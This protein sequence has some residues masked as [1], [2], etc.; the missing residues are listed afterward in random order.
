MR[1]RELLR[2]A[3]AG[4]R[5]NPL[6]SVLTALG[7]IIG[8]ASVMATLALGNGAR[9][10][11]E[12]QFRTLGS[13]QV[14]VTA[15]VKLVDGEVV[16]EGKPLSYTDGLAIADEIDLVKRVD[17]SVS[18]A[19]K[20]RYGRAAREMTVRGTA[21]TGLESVAAAGD[22]ALAD[23][24][25]GGSLNAADLLASGRYFSPAEAAG[26]ARVCVLG[27][28]TARELMAGE[29]PIGKVVR[30]G[31]Q[32]ATVIGVL[33]ELESTK[34]SGAVPGKPNE[35]FYVPVSL[36][37]RELA[38]EEPSVDIVA[39][40]ED[41]ARI[42]ETQAA[43]TELLRK[44]HGVEKSI[45]GTWEDD[46]GVTTRT[47]V[48]GA[49]QEAAKTFALLLSA[50]AVVALVVGGIGIMNVMLVSVSERTREIGVRLA[51]GA[52]RRDIIRQFLI[53]AALLGLAGGL[54]GTAVGL[55]S[56]PAVS[57]VFDR[58]A[59]LDPRSIPLAFG[60]AIA[61]GLVF[62]VYPA[63]RASR[64]DPIEALRYE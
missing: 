46:F 31:R 16:P 12:Q 49:Q 4:L 34:D 47:E 13:D 42:K 17:M 63:L 20:V 7:V 28:T 52:R 30:V 3:L 43:I 8:V 14:G 58:P 57:A 38:D 23:R 48:L 39:H 29:D 9:V 11:V 18:G 36:A 37:V 21:A 15:K 1:T 5:S 33:K 24:A 19:A 61:T 22:L 53:E 60:V 50:M 45:D 54:L 26:A 64:L 10:A 44:R 27:Y 32:N 55:L 6:R 51:V 56:V 62:G 59:T 2:T 35:A 25:D 40:A 41:E